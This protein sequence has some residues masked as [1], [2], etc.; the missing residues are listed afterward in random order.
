MRDWDHFIKYTPWF[1]SPDE[2][3]TIG[4][5]KPWSRSPVAGLPRLSALLAS[6]TL[7]PVS[8]SDMEY[9]LLAWGPPSA[10]Q[11]WLCHP[12]PEASPGQIC[13]IHNHFWSVCGGIVE[14]FG[15]EDN[16]EAEGQD[17][18]LNQNEILTVTA[19]Q[20]SVSEAL[21][22]FSWIWE[23][24]GLTIPITPE[25]YYVVAVE[26]NTNL[27]LVHRE[28]GELILFAPDHAFQGLTILPGCPDRSLY[29]IDNVPDLAS[30]IE[31]CV[32]KSFP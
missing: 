18:W 21:D 4:E 12:P 8:V 27:T 30:W 29:T 13:P 25:E 31:D 2:I 28:S 17:W 11:G 23:D 6:A 32:L 24:G 26:A 22:V 7:T 10:R 14:R 20:Y 3:A 19:S 15:K 5:E 16:Y 9:E 1:L